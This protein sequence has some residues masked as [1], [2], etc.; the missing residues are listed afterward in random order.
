MKELKPYG[1][2]GRKVVKTNKN[3]RDANKIV[4]LVNNHNCYNLAFEK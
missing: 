2:D 1:P 3:W 4:S